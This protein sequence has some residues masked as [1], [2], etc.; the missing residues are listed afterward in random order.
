M[1]MFL[2]PG[3]TRSRYTLAFD[4]RFA[5]S[6]TALRAGTDGVGV[7]F[8]AAM[9][10]DPDELVVSHDLAA[11]VGATEETIE[12][13]VA[14]GLWYPVADGYLMENPEAYDLWTYF[15]NDY[16]KKIRVDVR[17]RVYDRDGHRCV[18]CG[19]DADLT[20]DHI[21]PWSKGGDDTVANLRTL[22]RSCNSRKG[23]RT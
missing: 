4:G 14:A 13:L 5:M 10:V 6:A 20:L 11:E 16:R 21:I 23:A 12:R 19:T 1:T 18:E 8:L 3:E 17:R 9:R 7:F 22:C 2:H 15:A